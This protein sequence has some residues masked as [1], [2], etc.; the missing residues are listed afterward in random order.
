MANSNYQSKKQRIS[1]VQSDSASKHST[2]VFPIITLLIAA[3]LWGVSWYPLRVADSYGMPG[4]WTTLL[5]Y[6]VSTLLGVILLWRN[7][8]EF[9]QQPLLLAIIAVANGWL[10]VAF[11]LA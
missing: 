11:I 7:F 3:T 6:G 10:N 9:Q 1:I 5:I 8:T 2:A 4:L